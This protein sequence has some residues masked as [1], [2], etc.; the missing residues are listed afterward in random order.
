MLLLRNIR[1]ISMFN[2]SLFRAKDVMSSDIVTTGRQTDI[3]K[4]INLMIEN[5]ITGLP[6]M[7]DDMTLAGII[8]EKDVLRLLYDNIG[9]HRKV[10]DF[11]T[12][13]VRCFDQ[14][15][16]LAEIVDCLTKNRFRRV[17]ILHEGKLTGIISRKDIISFIFRH[18][19]EAQG[20]V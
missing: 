5:N 19:C 15:D 2:I 18:N 20:T 11:M 10:E 3:Y 1:E 13:N 4:A 8:S 12:N 7:N 6:V 14:E 17:P 16:S 9:E